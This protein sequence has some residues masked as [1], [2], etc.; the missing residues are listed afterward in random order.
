MIYAVGQSQPG[1]IVPLDFDSH[2]TPINRPAKSGDLSGAQLSGREGGR[3][4]G[5]AATALAFNAQF[6]PCT[7]QGLRTNHDLR[8]LFIACAIRSELEGAF[9]IEEWE[10][11]SCPLFS[12]LL[13]ATL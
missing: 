8:R 11:R 3:N 1:D 10:R 12:L 5:T 2:S 6:L 4:L 13:T 9:A 7:V